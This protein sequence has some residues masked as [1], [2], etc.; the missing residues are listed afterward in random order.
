MTEEM[1]LK[2]TSLSLKAYRHTITKEEIKEFDGF[3]TK[4]QNRLIR[5]ME[6]TIEFIV[7]KVSGI[8]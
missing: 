6:G 1:K 5:S 7:N 8:W 2:I 4:T 3:D